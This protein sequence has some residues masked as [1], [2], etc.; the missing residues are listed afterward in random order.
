MT[1]IETDSVNTRP[2]PVDSLQI[3]AGQRYSFVLN[4]V[5]PIR[6]YWIR[7]QP[8]SGNTGFVGGLNSAILR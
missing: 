8:S 3:F 2:Y 6:S 4:A 1:I 5:Q 7:A